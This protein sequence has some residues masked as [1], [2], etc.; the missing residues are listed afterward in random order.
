MS[1]L[2]LSPFLP[3]FFSEQE[4]RHY[5]F[6]SHDLT[7]SVPTCPDPR[8]LPDAGCQCQERQVQT[9]P[10]PSGASANL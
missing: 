10:G 9:R 5:Y 4:Q 8:V 3:H 1:D 2:V 6:L 7:S